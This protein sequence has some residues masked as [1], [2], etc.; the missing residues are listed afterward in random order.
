M[1][2]APVRP[3]TRKVKTSSKGRTAY[4]SSQSR[5]PT[6]QVSSRNG[7]G[8]VSSTQKTQNANPSQPLSN[9]HANTSTYTQPAVYEGQAAHSAPVEQLA[10]GWVEYQDPSSGR[11]YYANSTTGETRWEKPVSQTTAQP[12]SDPYA[13]QQVQHGSKM[14]QSAPM[15]LASKYGD[16]FVT[17]ASH[18]ELAAQYGNVGTSNPYSSSR[19]GIAVVN[20]RQ[21]KAPVSGTF[22]VKKLTEMADSTDYK[23]MLDDLLAIVTTLSSLLLQ[24]SEKKIMSEVEKGTAIFSKRLGRGD[25]DADTANRVGQ[26]VEAVKNRDFSTANGIHTAM[27][28]SIWKENKDWL[29]GV[30]YLIQLSAKRM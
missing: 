6:S 26:I 16:G 10:P 21:E 17:S 25:I 3:A 29:K 2:A 22:N 27:V 15:K 11:S 4:G 7:S 12:A 8:P 19:P 5:Q 1:K 13:N 9:G 18:P 20:K 24:G 28:N 14:N 23:A 30:K